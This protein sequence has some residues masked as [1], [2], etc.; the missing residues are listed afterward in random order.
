MEKIRIDQ[1]HCNYYVTKWLESHDGLILFSD[2]GRVSRGGSGSQGILLNIFE[3]HKLP[4]P[5]IVALL[6]ET[7]ILIEIDKSTKKAETSF[8]RYKEAKNII[9]SKISLYQNNRSIKEIKMAF[10]Y[11]GLKNNIFLQ[12]MKTLEIYQYDLAF[13]FTEPKFPTLFEVLH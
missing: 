9:L 10:C 2:A 6:K 5:D 8:V 12:K 7:L 13:Y 1:S 3:S 11:T 4:I